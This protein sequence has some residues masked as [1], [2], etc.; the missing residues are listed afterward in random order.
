MKPLRVLYIHLTGAFGGSSRSLFEAVR[1]FPPGSVEPLFVTQRGTV[2]DFFSRLGR[3]VETR[4][5]TQFDDTRYSHYRGFRWLVL[6]RELAYLPATVRALREAR[7]L[8]PEVDLIHLNEFTGLIPL[9]VARRL[10]GAPA[11]VHVRSVARGPVAP[12]RRTRWVYDVMRRHAAGVV[13]IDETVRASLPA[14][15]PVEVIHNGFT[16]RDDAELAPAL[17]QRLQAL[18]PGAFKV[19]FVGNLLKVK[20][21]LELVEAARITRDAGLDVE[22]LIVG[23]DAGRSRGLR[24]RLLKLL[25]LRQDMR[26][27][28]EA[29]LDAYGLRDRVHLLGF[30]PNLA[31]LYRSMDVLC[32][33]SHYDAPGRPIFE[34][35]FFGV[36]AIA[37]I[38]KPTPDT[39]VHGESGLAI[40][41][42]DAQGLADAIRTLA[43]DPAA[44]KRM[45]DAAR[46]MAASNFDVTANAQQLLAL[47]RRVART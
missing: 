8:Q 19:G 25:G 30:T 38:R 42:G 27:E 1:A 9:L 36:P 20:G 46:R 10:F 40:S 26:A 24:A 17:A 47:Y 43:T 31:P 13:S 37:A 21:I 45:G 34:A 16:P 29:M 14:D 11:V 33:P 23:D 41:P 39:L 4:G 22:F 35:A 32:F 5:L 12:S 7:R 28:V 44:C 18:R 3:V 15:L 6:L 2:R